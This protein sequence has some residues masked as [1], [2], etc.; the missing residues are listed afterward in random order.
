MLP[1]AGLLRNP[2]APSMNDPALTVEGI[3]VFIE[4]DGPQTVLMIHGWPDTHRLWDATVEALKDQHRC[5]RFTLP[6][7]DP[8]KPARATSLAD[9][10][11]MTIMAATTAAMNIWSRRSMLMPSVPCG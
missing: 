8:H 11:G 7:F 10:I 2:I 6:G 3:D 4:G 9:M 1:A 5:V